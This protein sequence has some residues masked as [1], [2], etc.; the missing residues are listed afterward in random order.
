[1]IACY[2]IYSK[3][4]DTFYVG[5]TQESVLS[6]LEKHNNG[7]YNNTYSAISNDWSLFLIIDCVTLSQAIKIERHIKKMK[8]RVYIENLSKCTEMIEKLKQRFP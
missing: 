1:M 8:S 5:I 3:K 4:L 7:F 6:R 2:I